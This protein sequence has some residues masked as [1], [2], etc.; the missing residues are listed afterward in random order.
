MAAIFYFASTVFLLTILKE[1]RHFALKKCYANTGE[2]EPEVTR[3][4]FNNVMDLGKFLEVPVAI[5]KKEK[6]VRGS[7]N[8]SQ[9][10]KLNT[11]PH[12]QF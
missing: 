2:M 11:K 3:M 7:S 4:V 10:E 5:K 1:R 9:D 6:Y 12:D 8:R